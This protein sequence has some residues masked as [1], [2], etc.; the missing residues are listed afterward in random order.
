M[1]FVIDTYL[2]E[3]LQIGGGGGGGE[4]GEGEKYYLSI[5]LTSISIHSYVN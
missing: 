2:I 1:H 3:L 5:S 4:G